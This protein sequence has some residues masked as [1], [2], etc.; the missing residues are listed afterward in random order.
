MIA[1]PFPHTA[2]VKWLCLMKC[3][4]S[5]TGA[6][7]KKKRVLAVSS[8]SKQD[9]R[10]RM[11]HTLNITS[12]NLEYFKANMVII[13][14]GVWSDIETTSVCHGMTSSKIYQCKE[15]GK[16]QILTVNKIQIL[17]LKY[18]YH[19]SSKIIVGTRRYE[20]GNYI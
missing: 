18:S 6:L 10:G 2:R 8:S 11:G 19:L 15:K 9:D 14:T 3:R 4:L 13:L 20:Y 7:G 16:H 17:A 1:K 12:H 5:W